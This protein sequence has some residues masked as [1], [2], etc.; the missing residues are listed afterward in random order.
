[1]IDRTGGRIAT[2]DIT[3]TWAESCV[4][5]SDYEIYEGTIGNFHSHTP[6]FCTTGGATMKT[7]SP[8]PESTYYLVVPT[9][10]GREGSYGTSTTGERSVGDGSCLPQETGACM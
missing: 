4:S 6:I 5:G 10:E 9:N 2:T 3:L 7:F 1:M 8:A